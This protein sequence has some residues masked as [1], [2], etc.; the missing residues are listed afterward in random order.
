MAWAVIGAS[1]S[2]VGEI[3]VAV[4][5]EFEGKLRP[6]AGHN[7]TSGHH[8]HDIGSDVVEKALIVSDNEKASARVAQRIDAVGHDPQRVDIEP[9]IRLVEDARDAA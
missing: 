3:A 6:A 1:R 5:L 7:A 9:R 2:L 8:V 4:P